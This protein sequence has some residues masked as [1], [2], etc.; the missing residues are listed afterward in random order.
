MAGQH[1]G[2]V[3]GSAASILVAE[4]VALNLMQARNRGEGNI[5]A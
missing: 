3:Q 5:E 4:R 2:T 1:F